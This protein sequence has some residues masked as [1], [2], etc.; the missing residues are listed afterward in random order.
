MVASS[1]SAH[2]RRL[3]P[4]VQAV[5]LSIPPLVNPSVR[6]TSYLP[7]RRSKPHCPAAPP[8]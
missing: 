4:S 7:R 3:S 1:S 5:A 2:R 8:P 6:L